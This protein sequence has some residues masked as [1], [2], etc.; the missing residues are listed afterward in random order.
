MLLLLLSPLWLPFF[1]TY[2]HL[3]TFSSFIKYSFAQLF[4]KHI[5]QTLNGTF[6]SLQNILVGLYACQ[7]CFLFF[8]HFFSFLY[9]HFFHASKNVHSKMIQ[10]ILSFSQHKL[11]ANTLFKDSFILL[12]RPICVFVFFFVDLSY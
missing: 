12:L 11:F 2:P 4:S 9:I 1:C 7:F 8:Y 5:V 10:Y 3:N 6:V